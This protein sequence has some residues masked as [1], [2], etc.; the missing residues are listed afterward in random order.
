[1]VSRIHL[2]AAA[3]LVIL[4]GACTTTDP[5]TSAEFTAA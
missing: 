4:L 1:M 2:L 3:L 5:R